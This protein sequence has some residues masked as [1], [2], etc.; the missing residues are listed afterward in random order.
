MRIPSCDNVGTFFWDEG[1]ILS[2]TMRMDCFD[3]AT[4]LYSSIIFHM[5]NTCIGIHFV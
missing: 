1:R 2:I 4:L 5:A 3:L